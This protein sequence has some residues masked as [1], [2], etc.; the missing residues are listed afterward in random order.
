MHSWH[1]KM[2]LSKSS[3]KMQATQGQLTTHLTVKVLMNLLMPMNRL[4]LARQEQ[5]Q[6]RHQTTHQWV[7]S[8]SPLCQAVARGL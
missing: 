8:T 2:Q 5:L 7:E 6:P 4:L 3:Y 1:N